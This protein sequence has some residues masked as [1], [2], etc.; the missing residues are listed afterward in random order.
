MKEREKT[1]GSVHPVEHLIGHE[2]GRMYE[3]RSCHV[4]NICVE[5]TKVYQELRKTKISCV[6]CSGSTIEMAKIYKSVNKL[7]LLVVL[8]GNECGTNGL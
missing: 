7:K 5:R 8:F 4:G 3:T 6:L 1:N 2:V